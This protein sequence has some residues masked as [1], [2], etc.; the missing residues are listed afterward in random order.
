ML[1]I[2]AGRRSQSYARLPGFGPLS[3]Y[4]YGLIFFM[5]VGQAQS[6]VV[7]PSAL[8]FNQV[9]DLETPPAQTIVVTASD[10]SHI[11]FTIPSPVSLGGNAYIFLEASPT[12]GVTPATVTVS[13]AGG[14]V[15]DAIGAFSEPWP[16][17]ISAP[18]RFVP[19]SSSPAAGTNL[20]VTV[21]LTQPPPPI[22][23]SVINAATGMPGVVPGVPVTITGEYLAGSAGPPK[24]LCPKSRGCRYPAVVGNTMVS[25]NGS[26]AAFIGNSSPS[27]LTTVL[28]PY[29]ITGPS[30]Q[31]EL[32]HYSQK[33]TIT[34]PLST[35]SP[36]ICGPECCPPVVEG[37]CSPG[38]FLNADYSLNGSGNPAPIGSAVLFTAIGSGEWSAEGPGPFPLLG[39]LLYGAQVPAAP[40]S[41]TIGGQTAQV[42]YATSGYAGREALS[43]LLQV[44]AIVPPGLAPGPQ[45]V[46]LTVGNANT[47]FQRVTVEV[48]DPQPPKITSVLNAASYQTALSPGEYVSIFGQA[49]ATPAQAKVLYPTAVTTAVTFN[50]V[51]S[52]L[53]FKD[54][55]QINAI[56]PYQVAGDSTVSV[57]VSYYGQSTPFTVPLADTSPAI[58]TLT[59][60]GSGQGAIL[61]MDNTVNSTANPAPAGSV[62]QVYAT[63]AGLW[64]P[65]LRVPMLIN[66]FPPFPVPVAPVSLTIG[67]QTAQ[68]QFAG[69][70]PRFL[71]GILQVNAYV[72]AGL[73]PG[74]QPVVLKIGNFDNQLQ[75]VTVAVR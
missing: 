53:L 70:A 62:V 17:A 57:V 26:P 51:N 2:F 24:I 14:I 16:L 25:F 38:T 55:G 48:E 33:T 73:A 3:K 42:Q 68:I 20:T 31:M 75:Q 1:R 4:V 15:A 13:A 58:F 27:R 29:G 32:Q 41:V 9:A 7:K 34:V 18:L 66:P 64:D 39:T 5:Q 69:A 40:V 30:V 61:N 74:P 19:A 44:S 56:V 60:T 59:G 28:V 45:P 47:S 8:N 72:P 52:V 63:G 49:L 71:E 10:G 50:G 21:N 22:V 65:P 23:T 6:L 43:D 36:A 67:G 54:S 11:P 35:T 37:F 46:I 12:S